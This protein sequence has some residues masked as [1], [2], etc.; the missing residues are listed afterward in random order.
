MHPLQLIKQCQQRSCALQETIPVKEHQDR[1]NQ[2]DETMLDQ[3]IWND[4]R[5]AAALLKERQQLSSLVKDLQGIVETT[6]LLFEYV[7]SFPDEIDS[8]NDQ[9]VDLDKTINE[10]ELAQMLNGEH[11]KGA[12]ILTISSG[13]GGL[14]SS[15]WVSM[16]LRMYLRYADSRGY[17]VEMLDEKPS[18]EHSSICLDN[19]SIRV[20]G[21][22][23]YGF[24][25]SESGVMRLIRNSPFS[26]GDARHTSFAAVSVLP[27]VEDNIEVVIEEKDIEWQFVRS[28][29]SGGQNVNVTNSCARLKHLPSGIMIRAQTERSQHENKRLALKILKAKLFDLEAK[30]QE[31]ENDKLIGEQSNNAFGSQI[32]TITMAPYTLVKNHRSGYETSQVDNYLDGD[33]HQS[34]IS[35]LRNK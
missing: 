13:S 32:K 9:I 16:L 14:E 23:A 24:L 21:E 6:A 22:N 26:S 17:K 1:I 25:K 8:F 11:D 27:D 2:I 20:E 31:S 5:K 28:Q 30:K 12:A 35:N 3:T 18:A 34:L 33:I 4:N 19:V 10:F 7:D 29:G 15:N